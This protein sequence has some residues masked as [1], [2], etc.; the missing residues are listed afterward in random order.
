MFHPGRTA[1]LV[2]RGQPQGFFGQLHPAVAR[3]RDLPSEVY[4]FDVNLSMLLTAMDDDGGRKVSKLKA[5]SSFPGS[6]RDLAFFADVS[7][8]VAD[9]MTAMTKTGGKLLDSVELFDDYRGKGVPEGQRSLAF[10]L[11]YKAGDRTLK[12]K[13]VDP[14]HQK[15][16]AQLEK[17]FKV[18]LR[19]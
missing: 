2:L 15:V 18:E 5:F 11:M 3:D 7:V 8:S 1:A 10:R 14:V 19:S 13:D 4:L 17:K 6:S 9:L 16:R 12:D